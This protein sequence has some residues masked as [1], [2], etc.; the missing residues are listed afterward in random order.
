[1]KDSNIINFDSNSLWNK[2]IRNIRIRWII[3]WILVGICVVGL[4]LSILTDFITLE[5]IIELIFYYGG[6]SFGLAASIIGIILSLINHQIFRSYTIIDNIKI[7]RKVDQLIFIAQRKKLHLWKGLGRRILAISALAE[8]A[9]SNSIEFLSALKNDKKSNI[10]KHAT[11]AIE[12]INQKLA[13][14][15]EEDIIPPAK[16]PPYKDRN[17]NYLS[18]VTNDRRYVL[19]MLSSYI[20][21]LPF[22]FFMIFLYL[23]YSN[24]FQDDFSLEVLFDYLIF[25]FVIFIILEI[26]IIITIILIR[27]NRIRKYLETKDLYKLISM[28]TKSGFGFL[29]YIK[30]FTISALGDIGSPEANSV[31][32]N[33]INDTQI[34]IRS[35][36]NTALDLISIKNDQQ[37]RYYMQFN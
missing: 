27:F 18:L 26:L 25:F 28:T 31:L 21:T 15:N 34:E 2:K 10:R 33:L 17:N 8:L 9:D 12:E 37:N 5:P 14:Y 24:L 16:L 19:F 35:R 30:A 20:L 23:R 1:M 3:Y 36:A 6:L 11:L 13:I 32:I 22:L 7:D 29:R 4:A